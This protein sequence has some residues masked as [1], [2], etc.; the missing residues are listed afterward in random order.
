MD[1]FLKYASSKSI[2]LQTGE[3]KFEQATKAKKAAIISI[4]DPSGSMSFTYTNNTVLPVTLFPNNFNDP[5]KPAEPY[6]VSRLGVQYNSN[7]TQ[8]IDI[9]LFNVQGWQDLRS[10]KINIEA[11][12]VDN[13]LTRKSLYE[14]IATTY[15]NIVQLQDQLAITKENLLVSDTLV[16]IAQH[17]YNEGLL[18]KQDLSDTQVNYLNTA[19]NA[20]QIEF[21]IQQQY[22][23][24]KQIS[25]L[26]DQDSIIIRH[27]VFSEYETTPIVEQNNLDVSNALLKEKMA[28]VNYRKNNAIKF[29]TLS[30]FG[31]ESRVQYNTRS[32]LFDKNWDWYQSQYL[33]LRLT[34]SM[35]SAKQLGSIWESRYNYQISQRNAQQTKIQSELDHKNLSIAYAKAWSQFTTNRE[36]FKL[37]KDSYLKN[38]E[39]YQLGLI[40]TETTLN[41]FS[42]MVSSDY[43]LSGSVAAL[44]LAQ[45]KIDINNTIK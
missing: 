42:A 19:E 31:S 2:S 37:K 11:T 17:K 13:K 10:A 41:S 4:P 12:A 22:V 32:G 36:I 34:L 29:P 14:N 38:K 24:L 20:R 18:K 35:P 15:F 28:L 43:N 3:I 45:A 8:T 16:Q 21:Q 6:S 9:K 39:L 30:F 27:Q 26:P 33:G 25:D 7:W 1:T 44:L 23:L 40:S 5:S